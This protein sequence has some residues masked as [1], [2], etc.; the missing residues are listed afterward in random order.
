M[1]PCF[2]DVQNTRMPLVAI[3]GDYNILP[4]DGEV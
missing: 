1:N 4:N 3:V 2:L